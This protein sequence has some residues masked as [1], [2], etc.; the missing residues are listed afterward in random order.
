MQVEACFVNKDTV[1]FP[2][3]VRVVYLLQDSFISGVDSFL[4][5]SG[6]GELLE[7]FE[8]YRGL[9]NQVLVQGLQCDAVNL[10]KGIEQHISS[11]P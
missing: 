1:T 6:N 7:F 3:H 9:C 4:Y 8:C 10:W 2:F 5:F 11:F